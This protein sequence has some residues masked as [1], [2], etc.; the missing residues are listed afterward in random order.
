MKVRLYMYKMLRKTCLGIKGFVDYTLTWIVFF[1]LCEKYH[2]FK[3]KGVPFID[4]SIREK[5]S[6]HIGKNFKMN[7]G[8][9]GNQIGFGDSP[10]VLQA[11]GGSIVIG[12]N[13]GIS[14]TALIACYGAKIIIGN[15]TLLGSGVR[16]Y[17]T[18]FHSIDYLLRRKETRLQ[19]IV[20][21]DVSIG[22]DC[23]IGAGV[24]ILKGVV[25]GD[26]SVVGAGS[27]VTKNIPA[28][29]IWAGNPAVFIRSISNKKEL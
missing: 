9:A 13:V 6:I 28:D 5:S 24:T 22:N 17:T 14:Q 1:C 12:D 3:T 23:F 29:E 2:N 15:N 4:V 10:C 27:V 18:D 7:N 19:N 16:I 11:I 26:R 25:I 8:M 21:K 20:G